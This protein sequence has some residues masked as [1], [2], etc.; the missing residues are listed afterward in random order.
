MLQTA[1]GLE[2]SGGSADKDGSFEKDRDPV[3]V[4]SHP[5]HHIFL[6]CKHFAGQKPCCELYGLHRSQP[7]YLYGFAAVE[8][9]IY[10]ID[11]VIN[12]ESH[13]ILL[14]G[15]YVVYVHIAGKEEEGRKIVCAR[16]Q[17]KLKIPLT[18]ARRIYIR[19]DMRLH[20]IPVIYICILRDIVSFMSVPCELQRSETVTGEPGIKV[21]THLEENI[22]EPG[23]L[24]VYGTMESLHTIVSD[25]IHLYRTG[26]HIGVDCSPL[27]MHREGKGLP[28]TERQI[29]LTYGLHRHT[30]GCLINIFLL[31]MCR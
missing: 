27:V 1:V 20:C 22:K 25:R 10:I 21:F 19:I 23:S 11:I 15:N 24:A 6:T 8:D 26:T 17:R 29:F 18:A 14:S 9:E 4:I 16:S 3:I 31:C 7:L 13:R 12:R 28:G 30:I 2:A 5:Y